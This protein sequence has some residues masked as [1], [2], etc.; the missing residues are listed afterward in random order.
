MNFKSAKRRVSAPPEKE[1]TR[2]M[3]AARPCP[4]LRG[5]LRTLILIVCAGSMAAGASNN[6]T[7]LGP[8]T[9]YVFDAPSHAIRAMMGIP[10]A[11]YLSAPVLSGLDA[12]AISPDGSAALVIQAGRLE[13]YRGLGSAQPVL[14]PL[15]GGMAAG[16]FAWAPSNSAA[17]VYSAAEKQAQVFADLLAPSPAGVAVD[18]SSLAGQVS[19]LAYDGQRLIVA[20]SSPNGGGVYVMTPQSAP[21]LAAAAVS[22]AGIV[23]AGGDFYFADSQAQQIWQV[24]NYATQPA[25]A[26]FAAGPNLS[27]PAALQISGT[28]LYVANAGNRT[29]GVYD[30]AARSPLEAI[31]LNFA[32]A[33]LD[34]FGDLSVFLLNSGSQGN[35]PLY[36]LTDQLGKRAV[37]FVAGSGGA[38]R[39]PLRYKPQ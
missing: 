19:A 28:V 31:S 3:V 4:V 38:R 9:G 29:L 39:P 20:V 26:L 25:P 18:L 17:V 15:N 5:F 33:T 30:L 27:S 14:V 1:G 32:P 10:A 16:Q 37:Y 7:L 13:L 11:G 35:G 36:V 22:P 8:V 24:R 12:A 6:A 23:L 21:Q 34:R 2:G